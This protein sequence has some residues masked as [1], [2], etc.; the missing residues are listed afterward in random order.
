MTEEEYFRENYPD[1]CY[2]DKPLSPHWD[3]FHDGVEFGELKSEKKIKELEALNDKL[4]NCWNCKKSFDK[5]CSFG[6]K[7]EAKKK[8]CKEWEIKENDR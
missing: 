7:C 4:Q 3:F 2:G 1:S 5:S 8:K 6:K